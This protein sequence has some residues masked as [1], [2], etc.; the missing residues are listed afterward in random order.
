LR[1]DV[2]DYAVSSDL[3]RAYDTAVAIRGSAPVV[4][5]ARWREFAFGQWEGLTWDEIVE[6]F[7]HVREEQWS[8]AKDYLPDGG[9]TFD[10]VKARVG[11]ALH[12]LLASGYANIL[13]VTHAGPL[14]AVLHVFFGEREAQMQ[15]VFGVRFVPASVTRIAVHQGRAE[16]LLLNRC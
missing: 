6:R 14:H 1:D 11:E 2:F 12:E 7:P 15:E 9:D 5:D 16:L 10:A 4:K 3:M 8:S 13:V